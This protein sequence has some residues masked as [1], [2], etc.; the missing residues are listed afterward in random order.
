MIGAAAFASSVANASEISIYGNAHV[1]IDWFS[2]DMIGEPEDGGYTGWALSKGKIGKG[3]HRASYIGLKGSEAFD[4]NL[5]IIYQIEFG[6]PLTN[7]SD[8]DIDNGDQGIAGTIRMR[9]SYIGLKSKLGTIFVGR[10]DTPLNQSTEPLDLFNDSMADYAGTL[11]FHDINADNILA[12]I[13]P[14]WGGFQIFAGSIPGAGSTVFGEKNHNVI[15]LAEAYSLATTYTN[16]PWYASIAYEVMDEQLGGRICALRY[17]H[18]CND[19]KKLRAGLGVRDLNGFRLSGI[20]ENQR[21]INLTKN[22]NGKDN[23]ADVW[24]VQAGYAFGK[25]MIKGMYG[26]AIRNADSKPDIKSWAAGFDHNFGKRTKAY[27]IY[28]NV[29]I[30]NKGTTSEEWGKVWLDELTAVELGTGRSSWKGFS[31]GL[32]HKF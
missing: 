16:D 15:G 1:S 26:G 20:Y 24:Q 5:N 25:N 29:D 32:I 21:S 7:E 12:Y 9:D 14:S 27:L 6:V 8:Y 19:Y 17:R 11:E 28:T 2:I 31:L 23:D 18:T 10:H 3:N 22:I 30:D 13:S 4:D